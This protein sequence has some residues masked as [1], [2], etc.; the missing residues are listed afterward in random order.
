M[1]TVITVLTVNRSVSVNR[2]NAIA[3]GDVCVTAG[4]E[5]AARDQVNIIDFKEAVLC[6]W[7][8]SGL[9]PYLL[10]ISS[11]DT[12]PVIV[13]LRDIELNS[14]ATYTVNCSASGRPAPLHGE[15]TLVKPDKTTVY[16]SLVSIISL[17]RSPRE[18]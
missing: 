6:F 4:T 8:I 18:V 3:S 2:A 16:V 15:I 1:R 14:G 5:L 17:H 9:N 7:E 13:S 10:V 11:K 12:R